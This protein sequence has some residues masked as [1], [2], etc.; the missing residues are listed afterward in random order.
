[1]DAEGE[2][3]DDRFRAGVQS[4]RDQ[5]WTVIAASDPIPEYGRDVELI[6]D[7]DVR[8]ATAEQYVALCADAFGIPAR[9]GIV[10]YVS[11]GTDDDAVGVLTRFGTRGEVERLLEDGEEIVR[12]RIPRIEERRV[13]ESRLLTAMEAALNAE[14]RIEFI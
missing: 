10:T 8:N 11:R 12:V 9:P 6:I 2:L 7:V 3:S 5:G 14:V 1:M 4:L 13:P